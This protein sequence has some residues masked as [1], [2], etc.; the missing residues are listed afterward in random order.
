MAALLDLYDDVEVYQLLDPDDITA[1][2]YSD[3]I[4][5]NKAEG[6]MFIINVGTVT[7][8]DS[9]DYLTPKLMYEDVAAGST[10]TGSNGTEET[11]YNGTLTKIDATT[12][13][14][15]VQIVSIKDTN[16]GQS[17]PSK[18]RYWWIELAE[19]TDGTGVN[20]VVGITAIKK[21]TTRPSS[22]SDHI[23]TGTTVS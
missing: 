10:P 9:N 8:A 23:R 22:D 16:D 21:P 2:T 4:D 1:T 17:D 7:T 18:T 13:G 12:E 15:Q 3:A 5:L 14:D 20:M 19:T 6:A 11:D